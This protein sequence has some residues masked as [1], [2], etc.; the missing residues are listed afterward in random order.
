MTINLLVSGGIGILVAGFSY[1]YYKDKHALSTD[2]QLRP[3]LTMAVVLRDI[4]DSVLVCA[5]FAG[6]VACASY[7][8]GL[9][10]GNELNIKP[11]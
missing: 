1:D 8:G 2:Y 9:V 4:A 11:R 10:L 6:I 7:Y 3:D 5:I